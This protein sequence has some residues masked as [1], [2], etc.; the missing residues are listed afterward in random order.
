MSSRAALEAVAERLGSPS[1]WGRAGLRLALLGLI[2]GGA[3]TLLAASL[4]PA[5]GVADAAVDAARQ[6]LQAIPPLPASLGEPPERSVVLAR[7][8]TVL[9]TLRDVNRSAVRLSDVPRH[10]VDAVVATE[11]T[12]FRQHH[13]VN[14]QAVARAAVDNVRAGQVT[15]GGSTITQQLVK[16]LTGDAARSL[17]R[18][19]RE[20]LW[21]IDLERQL[22]KDQILE[23][24]L[25]RA[26]FGNA[27]YG[28]GTAAEY[29]WGKPV[30]Q[31]TVAEGALLAGIIRAPEDNEP[32]G[33]PLA[34]VL[35]RNIVLA[36]MADA[37]LLGAA[38][39]QRLRSAPPA[40]R[41]TPPRPPADPFLVAYVRELLKQDPALG[42]D[43]A[44]RDYAA[45][46]GGLTV[47]TTFDPR[48]Q[49][50]A[51]DAIRDVLADPDGPQAAL[52]VVDP[53]SGEILAVGTGP[54]PFGQGSGETEVTAA[55]PGLGSPFGRQPGSAFK[56]FAIVAAL[57]AGVPTG[58]TIDTP[59]PYLS[60]SPACRQ[61]DGTSW[62]PG[63]YSDAG[64]GVMDMPRATA[65]SSN[66]YF[67]HLVDQKT[68]PQALVDAARRLGITHSRLEPHCSAVLGG[69][70]VFPL[71]MASA[72]GTLANGG[73]RCEPFAVAEVH[74][75]HGRTIS[76]RDP[77][78][79]R[80]VE[81]AVAAQATALLRGPLEY[82]T[83]SRNGALGRPAAGKTGTTQDYG[84]AWFI[85]YV[86]QLSAA[87]W[88]GFEDAQRAMRDSRCGGG[89]TGGC[90]PT[91]IWRRFMSA[92]LGTLGRPPQ[93]FPAPPS[94]AT[95]VVPGV[96]GRPVA[97]AQEIMGR[98]RLATPLRPLSAPPPAGVVVAQEPPAGARVP[99]PGS[100]L[101]SV[102]DGSG[103][104][105]VMPDLVGLTTAEA[106]ARLRA[107]GLAGT[108]YVVAVR[109]PRLDG[110]V[111]D[112][113]PPAG[114]P[115]G[116][117]AV[118]VSGGRVRAHGDGRPD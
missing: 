19:L 86:P 46:S 89:V 29:Y 93:D 76:R 49:E 97:E 31:L 54:K 74:D 67:A 64:G 102:S 11:D 84:D 16:Q 92:A 72:F 37:G 23:E 5:A 17:E 100:V 82:G 79:R 42:N 66:V 110:R 58:Y 44:A 51:V 50:L 115:V 114:S 26:Y 87:T 75:R 14:W 62:T 30:S 63:N 65:L 3:G 61:T 15:S 43:P 6:R 45:L 56:P 27:V 53:R 20:A 25:N 24:Y 57:E 70:E 55:V 85:G 36:Q 101:L 69:E 18:K 111:V 88:V 113:H 8:G 91:M 22:T 32:V 52:A 77:D 7:D 10:V 33:N 28:I 60:V 117:A 80:A 109:D 81:P 106:D 116:S 47:R 1:T 35:R 98:L 34:A 59:S 90:L 108:M 103:G 83:A 48:L 4:V 118:T 39:A 94:P 99:V 96:V 9:A 12:H 112:Q 21:A 13:G 71:D 40:L 68:G 105:P 73:V 107:A 104:G 95:T 41:V 78:C 38:D 2:V